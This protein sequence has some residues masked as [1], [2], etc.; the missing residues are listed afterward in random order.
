MISQDVINEIK[1]RVEVLDLAERL[2][3]HM[4]KAG[5]NWVGRCPFHEEKDGS[6][7]IRPSRNDWHCFGCNKG[8]NVIDFY[9]EMKGCSFIEAVRE[10]ADM[11]GIQIQE[12][13]NETDEER[14]ARAKRNAQLEVNKMAAHWFEEQLR[15]EPRAMEYCQSRGWDE[16]TLEKWGIGYAPA[17][18]D[19]LYK[20]LRDVRKVKM[21]V[22]MESAMFSQNRQGGYFCKF[23]E[24]VMFP[25]FDQRHEVVG[26]SGRTVSWAKPI[27]TAE[28]EKEPSKYINTSSSQK[29]ND[30]SDVYKKGEL[31][32]GWNFARGE[33]KS[34]GEAILVEGNPDVIRLHQVGIKNAC[35]ACGTAFTPQQAEVLKKTVGQVVLIYDSDNAGQAATMKTGLVAAEAGLAVSILTLPDKTDK[36]G[37][38]ITDANGKTVKHDPDSFFT[39]KEQ[40]EEYANKNKRSWFQ[41][42]G[43]AKAAMLGKDPDPAIE[44]NIMREL[45]PLIT[46]RDEEEQTAI[47]AI[48][49]KYVGTRPRWKQLI[50]VVT[51]EEE[52][53]TKRDGY[54]AEQLKM[55]DTYGFCMRQNCYHIQASAESGWRE[56]SN[57]VLEP[58]FHIES[59]VNAKRLYRLKN[60]RGVVKV[61]E[62]PQ[63]DLISLTAFKTRVESFGN[64]LF[65]GSDTDLNKIKAYLYEATKSCREVERLGWQREGF[66]AWSNGAVMESGEMLPI[67]E[68]G[69]VEVGKQ[70]YY[71]PALSSYYQS[72][73]GLFSYERQFVHTASGADMMTLALKMQRCYGD[74]AVVGIAFYMATLFRDIVYNHFGA[75]PI[76]NIFGQKGTGKSTMALT[77]MRLFSQ[78]DKPGDLLTNST[79]PGL[80]MNLSRCKN[81]LAHIDEYKNNEDY[82]KIELLKGVYNSK[83]RSRINI[84]RD[85]KTEVTPIDCGL[86]L[87]GQEIPNADPALFGRLI[88]LTVSK[89]SFSDDDRAALADLK[90]Y[91]KKGLTDI[92]NELLQQREWV[93]EHYSQAVE[94][95]DVELKQLLKSRS[96]DVTRIRE[97]WW[98][99]LAMVKCLDGRVNL[100]WG[101]RDAVKVFVEG[102]ERQQASNKETDELGEFWHGVESMLTNGDIENE[103]DLLIYFGKSD[104]TLDYGS[105]K[106]RQKR[107]YTQTYDLLYVNPDRLFDAYAQH[108]KRVKDNKA[109]LLGKASLRHYLTTCPE[110]MGEAVRK[111]KVPIRLRQNPGE[112]MGINENGDKK[113]LMKSCRALV[114]NYGRLK[115]NYGID[116]DVQ[117]DVM[118]NPNKPTEEVPY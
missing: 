49:A 24:R 88:Y 81:A 92:T 18:W 38:K 3:V 33:A 30:P 15:K 61:L 97:N 37:K 13:N 63:K 71:L 31:L 114:F 12:E 73:E 58:L 76:L 6:F 10:L 8:G 72:D 42:W 45:V 108:T 2:G 43:E 56:V 79:A 87:T 99:V 28:G 52:S 17:S 23:Q 103:Y 90:A 16:E 29:K 106:D 86:I 67:D 48:L 96:S 65:T 109:G 117:S 41:F 100:P 44:T 80:A 113:V 70:W 32:F 54:S 101:Y 82:L 98:M 104:F 47:I 85:K 11:K 64:F 9:M 102:I 89:T 4:R 62:I 77:L 59:T 57:F 118:E 19:G 68:L 111:F 36:D 83:G 66:W 40:Y 14:R 75:F 34:K 22:L 110:F 116:L 105:G 93:A 60:N 78:S 69:T 84:D 55:I 95:V 25:V 39:S 7:I 20:Y 53:K 94:A 50:K 91:E 74:N 27:K 46:V 115:E 5:A 51:Q 112:G 1:E 35:A 107:P 26:F 21:E